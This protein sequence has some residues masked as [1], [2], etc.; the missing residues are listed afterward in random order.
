[1]KKIFIDCG[2]NNGCSVKMFVENFEDSREYEIYSFECSDVFY[3][4]LIHNVS[5]L[6]LK[7]FHPTKKAV[8]IS[9]CKK[10]FTGWELSD[11]QNI[12]DGGGVDTVDIS[13]FIIDNFSKEDFIIM[14]MDIEG[15]EYKVIEKMHRDGSLSYINKFYGELH[16][17]KK[18]FT[19][20]D[21]I[22]LL[23]QL[24][25]FGLKLYNWDALDSSKFEELE[26]VPFD[27]PGSYTNESSK[28]VGHAYKRVNI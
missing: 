19:E 1:M 17:P 6:N 21:N 25:D 14:K 9:N 18:G 26:I 10:R 20:K 16:G 22:N 8:W 2:A 13:Q 4:E 5:A 24:A 28:R 23:N 11:K 15:A 27:T 7:S 3:K 12:D